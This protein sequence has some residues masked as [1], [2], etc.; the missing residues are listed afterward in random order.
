MYRTYRI[1]CARFLG[2]LGTPLTRRVDQTHGATP[3]LNRRAN[4]FAG[5]QD[6]PRRHQNLGVPASSLHVRHDSHDS[7]DRHGL[8]LLLPEVRSRGSL[9]SRLICGFRSVED[10]PTERFASLYVLCDR[11]AQ[12]SLGAHR[13][14][15]RAECSAKQS[16]PACPHLQ[17]RLHRL[18]R[19]AADLQRSEAHVS[20][21]LPPPLPLDLDDAPKYASGVPGA[22]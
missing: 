12:H 9:H 16:C 7:H 8:T 20:L 22:I 15:D 17:I 10:H 19:L 11:V 6:V 21:E 14:G 2:S 13:A 3:R 4:F 5:H 1:L 18:K